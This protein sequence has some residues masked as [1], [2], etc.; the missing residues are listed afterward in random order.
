MDTSG[1]QV[2]LQQRVSKDSH[3]STAVCD[4]CINLSDMT[5]NIGGYQ[6]MK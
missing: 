4:I 5:D 3:L 6:S 1:T 2:L